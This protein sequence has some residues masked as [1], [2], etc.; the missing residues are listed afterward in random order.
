MDIVYKD[1]SYLI[2]G[3]CFEVYKEKGCGFLE[4]VFQ[5]CLG[6]EL[7]DRGIPCT[8]DQLLESI[9]HAAWIAR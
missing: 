4:A 8:N 2:M 3:A 9:R 6:M 1:E 5:E 7:G